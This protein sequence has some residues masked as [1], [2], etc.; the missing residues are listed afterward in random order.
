MS[1]CIAEETIN[2]MKRQPM[3]W[4]KILVNNISHKGLISKIHQVKVKVVESCLILW[5][6]MDY[7]THGILQA[8]ILEWVA[9]LFSR[10]SSQ[11]WDH[12]MVSSI[13]GRFFTSWA[14]R[15]ASKIYKEL[16]QLKN[17]NTNNLIK[18][19]AVDL[20]RYF[21]KEDTQMAN[22]YMNRCFTWLVIRETHIKPTMR[23]HFTSDRYHQK[24]KKY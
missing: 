20:N 14:T 12:T 3:K 8:R 16:I 18:K 11:P 24:D 10:G 22:R 6:P 13:A 19:W 7:T 9:F 23:Y 17:K 21:S 2:I 5:D 1:F 15:E 4:E